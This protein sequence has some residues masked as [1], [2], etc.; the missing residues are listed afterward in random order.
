MKKIS[1]FVLT[2]LLG[3]NIA[4]SAESQTKAPAQNSTVEIEK[5]FVDSKNYEP[6]K[7]KKIQVKQKVE[8]PVKA[9]KEK[10]KKTES[11]KE[12]V[13]TSS[14]KEVEKQAKQE[15]IIQRRRELQE[16]TDLNKKAVALYTD[17]NLK[18]S[19]NTFAKIPED[20]RTPEIWLLMGNILMDQGKKDEAVFMYG[21]AILVDPTYY[22]AYYN[23]GNIYL[24]EDKFNMAIEQYKQATKY[25]QSNPYVFYNLGCAY[26]KIGDLKK[27]R[28]AYLNALEIKNTI[29]EIHYNLAYVLKKLKKEKQAK[30]FLSNYNKLTGEI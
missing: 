14:L 4:T 12:T 20:K 22:K 8:K 11:Q 24:S 7:T 30:I 9:K 23:L 19:L 13:T 1:V 5:V 2:T 25:T 6:Q 28:G 18:E 26:L 3:I 27:A 10:I 21:R 17:N 16:L 15:E 29:P